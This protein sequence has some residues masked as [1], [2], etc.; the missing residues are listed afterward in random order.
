M[1]Q[2]PLCIPCIPWEVKISPQISQNSQNFQWER[3]MAQ[4]I[5][6][7]PCIPWEVKISPQISQNSQ[8]FQWERIMAQAILCI[9]CIPWE[10]KISP[11]IS[12]NFQWEPE[13]VDER[14]SFMR[15]KDALYFLADS[16]N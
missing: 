7:I 3:I 6:C 8:N 13:C 10:V 12:Q 2:A 5:L 14:R 1:A 4:A 15:P 9:P 11:Q 16:N